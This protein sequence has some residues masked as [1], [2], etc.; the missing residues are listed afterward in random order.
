MLQH[1]DILP[2]GM[3]ALVLVQPSATHSPGTTSRAPGTVYLGPVGYFFAG[4]GAGAVDTVADDS[5]PPAGTEAGA[6]AG[7]ALDVDVVADVV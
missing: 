6:G 2:P 7:A 4:A 1:S 3:I 5:A